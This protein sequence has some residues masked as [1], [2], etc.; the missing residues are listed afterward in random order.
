MKRILFIFLLTSHSIFSG[1]GPQ[2]FTVTNTNDS[3]TGSF[4]EAVARFNN[5]Y[6]EDDKI[7][8]ELSGNGPFYIHLLSDLEI[9][10][11]NGMVLSTVPVTIRGNGLFKRNHSSTLK[12]LDIKN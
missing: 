9:S 12:G 7:E 1:P 8:F 4:R 3:G 10:R 2:T 5:G 6:E 11:E